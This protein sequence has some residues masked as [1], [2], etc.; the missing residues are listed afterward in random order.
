MILRNHGV[1]TCGATI[2]EAF[3]RMYMLNRSCEM[4]IAALSAGRENLIIPD[5]RI[6]QYTQEA[7]AS[8][9]PEGVG[10]KEFAALMRRLDSLGSSYMD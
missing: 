10:Q 7:A 6:L 3:F 9:N 5:Q 8:F 4:Q 2:A 1:L